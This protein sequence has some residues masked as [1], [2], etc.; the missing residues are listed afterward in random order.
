[1]KA[2][3]LDVLKRISGIKESQASESVSSV[4]EAVR[5]TEKRVELLRDYQQ[6]TAPQVQ[7]DT[8]SG[9]S[10]HALAAFRAVTRAAEAQAESQ[11]ERLNVDLEQVVSQWADARNE[12]RILGEKHL[13]AQKQERSAAEKLRDKTAPPRHVAL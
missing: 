9:Q 10:L 8:V 11:L 12:K 13:D 7:P 5:K 1:M 6:R 2:H 3:S 4:Q